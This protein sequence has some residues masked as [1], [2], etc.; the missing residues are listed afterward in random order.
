[1]C[2]DR[3]TIICTHLS[4]SGVVECVRKHVILLI[5]AAFVSSKVM[6]MGVLVMIYVDKSYL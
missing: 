2:E 5:E 4:R 1:M 6:L 3:E